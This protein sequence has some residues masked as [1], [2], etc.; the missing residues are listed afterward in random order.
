MPRSMFAPPRAIA[1]A[2]RS[3]GAKRNSRRP[4][5]IHDEREEI[6]GIQQDAAGLAGSM[7]G[8]QPG[9]WPSSCMSTGMYTVCIATVDASRARLFAY[10]RASDGGELHE[11]ITELCDLVNPARRLRPAQLF[12]DSRPGSSRTSGQQFGFDDHRDAHI[13]ELDAAF[14]RIVVTAI[15]EQLAAHQG[16]RLIVCASPRMLGE[17][18]EAGSELRRGSLAIDEVPRDLVKFSPTELR[19][20]LAAYGL[21]PPRPAYM[22]A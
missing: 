12:S 2:L 10:E 14:S 3:S 6:T 5:A 18:R 17:L 1:H 8:L 20:R 4:A 21:L 16:Q 19:D 11:K 9:R 15:A 7:S 13:D 22:Q